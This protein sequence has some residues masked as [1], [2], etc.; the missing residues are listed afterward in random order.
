MANVDNLHF[1]DG[2]SDS[3][4]FR[5]ELHAG[6]RHSMELYQIIGFPLAC[7]DRFWRNML[8]N[9]NTHIEGFL[10]A[11]EV[12]DSGKA[13][14]DKIRNKLLEGP[15]HMEGVGRVEVDPLGEIEVIAED[16]NQLIIKSAN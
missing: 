7:I 8:E 14:V 10:V 2:R 1:V 15:W 12:D 11:V 16:D 9:D 5:L 13:T 3:V 4:G 6:A